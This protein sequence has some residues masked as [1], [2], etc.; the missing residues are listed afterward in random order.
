VHLTRHA[1]RDGSAESAI[2]PTSTIGRAVLDRTAPAW[3]VPSDA[4]VCRACQEPDEAVSAHTQARKHAANAVNA[5]GGGRMAFRMAP[6]FPELPE[7]NGNR[8]ALL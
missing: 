6:R 1:D 4:V 3:L 5:R 2:T 8:I 7:V